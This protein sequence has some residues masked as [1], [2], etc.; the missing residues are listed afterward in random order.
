M[1]LIFISSAAETLGLGMIMPL[2]ASLLG[3]GEGGVF[4]TMLQAVFGQALTINTILLIFVFL[5]STRFILGVIRNYMMYG[6]EWKLRGYWM[7]TFYQHNLF[8][9]NK[10]NI[11]A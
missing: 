10:G 5:F 1:M 3:D 7:N 2:L 4:L 9:K 6:I 11:V 8:Q